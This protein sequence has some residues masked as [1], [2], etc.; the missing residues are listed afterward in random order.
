MIENSLKIINNI[1]FKNTINKFT[2]TKHFHK[3][4][5][6]SRIQIHFK[7]NKIFT[8]LCQFG[9]IKQNVKIEKD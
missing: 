6:K 3:T 1:N 8:K 2:F 5:P 4:L 9:E 7:Y